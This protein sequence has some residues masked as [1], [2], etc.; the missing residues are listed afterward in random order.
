MASTL[1]MFLAGIA[2]I[3]NTMVILILYFVSNAFLA[4]LLNTMMS[5][6]KGPQ[7]IPIGQF[8]YL[9]PFLYGILLVFEVI[10]I[11][12]FF[13]VVGRRETIDDLYN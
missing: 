3:V 1:S 6:V 9:F 5:I 10:L 12:A 8:T 4:P 11:I 7:A 13:V 2:L